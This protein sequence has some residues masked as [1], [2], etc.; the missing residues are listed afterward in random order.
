VNDVL[1]RMARED[2]NQLPV[3]RDGQLEGVVSRGHILSLLQ[4][5][6]ELQV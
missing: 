1:E 4:T 6:A 5:R 3:V 2:L